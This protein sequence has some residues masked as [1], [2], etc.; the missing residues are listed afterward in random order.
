MPTLQYAFDKQTSRSRDSDGRMRVKDCILSTAEVN[1]YNGR[2]IPG[3]DKLGLNPDAVYRMYR[4]PEALGA[5]VPTHEGNPLMVKHIENTGSNPNHEYKGGSVH[6]IRFDGKHLR[7]DLL[8]DDAKA[9]DLVETEKASDL[10][11]GYRYTPRM[12]A[13]VTPDGKAYDGVMDKIEGNHVALV[14]DGR[15]SGAHVADAAHQPTG[16]AAMAAKAQNKAEKDNPANN[17]NANGQT[18][19]T[20]ADPAPGSPN[21]EVNEQQNLAAVGQALKHIAELLENIHSRLPGGD[22]DMANDN[23]HGKDSERDAEDRRRAHDEELRGRWNEDKRRRAHDAEHEK[24]SE[25]ERKTEDRQRIQGKEMERRKVEDDRRRAYDDQFEA[26]EQ[27]GT[28]ARGLETP[29]GAMDAKTVE[30]T[31]AATVEAAVAA[32]RQRGKAIAEARRDVASV[33]G[34]VDGYAFDSADGIYREALKHKGVDVTQIAEGTARIAWQG[35]QAGG[36]AAP[37]S[38]AYAQDANAVSAA[39]ETS[40]RLAGLA[41]RISVKG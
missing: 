16:D 33:L 3:W 21:G 28:G 20:T 17:P 34:D 6:S 2:E 4:S 5:S 37:R 26:G 9:Q 22:T 27:D 8:I 29:H 1:P 39:A 19:G 25:D 23:R 15:A 38:P 36:G 18:A 7:G 10:S 12:T 35:Y 11:A 32:E 14:D 41:A 40:K 30:T 31:I 13:G 24:L